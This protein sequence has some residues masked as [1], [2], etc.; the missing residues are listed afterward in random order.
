MGYCGLLPVW[1]MRSRVRSA[2]VC[3]LLML[4]VAGC[5]ASDQE[6]VANPDRQ[7]ERLVRLLSTKSDADS[8][9]AAGLLSIG[10]HAD[11][12]N[13]LLT[14]AVAAAPERPYLVWLQ[15]QI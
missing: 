4:V 10:K 12:S 6:H 8:L 15:A 3:L 5:I 13:A 1:S 11:E 2:A 14:R 9:A 7:L